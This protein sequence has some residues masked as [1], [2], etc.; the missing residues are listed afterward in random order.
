M[1]YN[2]GVCKCSD[3]LDIY[4]VMNP[5]SV[6]SFPPIQG[7]VCLA[8]GQVGSYYVDPRFSRPANISLGIGVDGYDWSVL[9]D[10]T[11]GVGDWTQGATPGATAGLL[12]SG[13]NSATEIRAPSTG[14]TNT[15]A[16]IQVKQGN[17]CNT[18]VTPL[19]INRGAPTATITA[20]AI[21][22]AYTNT[23]GTASSV[24]NNSTQAVSACLNAGTANTPITLTAPA[25]SSYLWSLPVA[26]GFSLASGTLTQQ[27]ITVNAAGNRSGVIQVTCT[28]LS[29]SCG[30]PTTATFTVTR[31]LTS[32]NVIAITGGYSCLLPSTPGPVYNGTVSNFPP[33]GGTTFEIKPPTGS[34]G[35]AVSAISSTGTFT[36]STPKKP[37][38]F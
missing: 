14:W 13:D 23:G 7:P 3:T 30:V 4:R 24:N 26:G 8:P 32:A 22:A 6:G 20:S 16:T 28:P 10:N 38:R 11:V 25:G 1:T 31:R 17:V 34:S 27:T 15:T 36:V 29:G 9:N 37:D 18:F 5:Q 21:D 19:V 12:A 35:I 33:D 2:G